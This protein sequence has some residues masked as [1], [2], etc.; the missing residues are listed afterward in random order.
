M[1][2]HPVIP[3]SILGYRSQNLEQL[4]AAGSRL[5]L[6]AAGVIPMEPRSHRA[7]CMAVLDLNQ[8]KSLRRY[9]V[10]SHP[11]YQQGSPHSWWMVLG[12]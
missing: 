4:R 11:R 6:L 12:S 2:P 1:D 10:Q 3:P 9:M 7:I 5:R 8:V